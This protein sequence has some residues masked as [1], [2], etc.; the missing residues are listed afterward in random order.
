M[1]SY[2]RPVATTAA[3]STAVMNADLSPPRINESNEIMAIVKYQGEFANTLSSGFSTPTVTALLSP[4]VSS[5]IF[6]VTHVTA[7]SEASA[8]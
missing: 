1:V 4:A 7:A 3:K 6:S 5:S 8:T 2:Q